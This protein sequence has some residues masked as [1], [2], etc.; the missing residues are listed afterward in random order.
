MVNEFLFYVVKNGL[1][2]VNKIIKDLDEIILKVLRKII[3][4]KCENE[5]EEIVLLIKN[6]FDP[7][8][9]LNPGRMYEDI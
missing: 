5:I 6:N 4:I 1:V 8:G 9:V 2:K 7:F 3:K